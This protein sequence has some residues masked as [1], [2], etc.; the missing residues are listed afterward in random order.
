M[1]LFKNIYV[2]KFYF[3]KVNQHLWLLENKLAAEKNSYD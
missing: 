2:I 1:F 3:K